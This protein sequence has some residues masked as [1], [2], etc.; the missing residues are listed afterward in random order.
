MLIS[1]ASY[2]V[3]S[4]FGADYDFS[5]HIHAGKSSF[6]EYGD[7]S[8][9]MEPTGPITGNKLTVYHQNVPVVTTRLVG[10]ENGISLKWNYQWSLWERIDAAEGPSRREGELSLISTSGSALWMPFVQNTTLDIPSGTMTPLLKS[11][12][13][14]GET[15]SEAQFDEN[16]E[17]AALAIMNDYFADSGLAA[18]YGQAIGAAF[19]SGDIQF[20]TLLAFVLFLLFT[21]VTLVSDRLSPAAAFLMESL[22]YLGFFGTLLGMGQALQILGFANLS[23]GLQKAI[24]LGPIGSQM[25]LAI[26]TT[27]FALVL[28]LAAGVISHVVDVIAE[29]IR[30]AAGV[31]DSPLGPVG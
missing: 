8:F 28:Y 3:F 19:W 10:T 16:E 7:F 4:G 22:P 5:K 24:S 30:V 31:E 27:K 18:A 2:A 14:Y 15:I 13:R 9:F 20:L 11:L 17:Q 6:R 21:A 25:G 29:R 23:D 26:E 1:V 12:M